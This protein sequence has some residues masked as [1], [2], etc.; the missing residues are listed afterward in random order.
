MPR[1]LAAPLQKAVPE[2]LERYFRL[3]AAWDGKQYAQLSN[4]DIEWLDQAN[5]R[6]G[7][8]RVE[9]LYAAW[10][11]GREWRMLVVDARPS[12][13]AEFST[14]LVN[15]GGQAKPKELGSAR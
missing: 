7:D 6:F 10:A 14:C 4:N 5:Q 12:S 13:V 2:E 9:G 8:G 11:A 3:R 1:L 15:A